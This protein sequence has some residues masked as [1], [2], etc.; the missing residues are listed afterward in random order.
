MNWFPIHLHTLPKTFVAANLSGVVIS[1]EINTI[2]LQRQYNPSQ[3]W[4]HKWPAAESERVAYFIHNWNAICPQELNNVRIFFSLENLPSNSTFDLLQL[5]STGIS[6]IQIFHPQSSNPYIDPITGL[7]HHG[8][9]LLN[10][11]A[12]KNILLDLSHLSGS[13]LSHVLDNAPGP[14]IVSHVVCSTLLQPSIIARANAMT[15][16]ELCACD[17]KLYGLPFIDDLLSPVGTSDP[18]IRK[19]DVELLAQHIACMV[20]IVGIDRVAL[21]PDFFLESDYKILGVNTVSRMDTPFGLNKLQQCL[22][23]KGFSKSNIDAI[24]FENALHVMGEI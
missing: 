19:T 22:H 13:L 17:A 20:E 21:G 16:E 5:G 11:I 10:F 1:V 12:E 24:F 4:M 6:S 7:S 18:S 14:K 2:Q 9:A 3:Q 23:H 15:P 8:Y